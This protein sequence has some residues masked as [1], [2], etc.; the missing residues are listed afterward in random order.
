MLVLRVLCGTLSCRRG[1]YDG[2]SHEPEGRMEEKGNRRVLQAG[3]EEPSA[4][5][6]KTTLRIGAKPAIR[7]YILLKGIKC[8]VI[9]FI[10]EI[11]AQNNKLQYYPV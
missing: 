10:F 8:G 11:T 4:A 9:N 2:F 5:Q 3:D 6:Q 7:D 1:N